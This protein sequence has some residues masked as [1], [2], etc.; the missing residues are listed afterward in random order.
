MKSS[1]E[2]KP[3]TKQTDRIC[4]IHVDHCCSGLQDF[5]PCILSM[6]LWNISPCILACHCETLVHVSYCGN[7]GLLSMCLSM[8]LCDFSPHILAWHCGRNFSPCIQGWHCKS[9]SAAITELGLDDG[10]EAFARTR[11]QFYI[12]KKNA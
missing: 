7:V 2:G 8:A 5:S 1:M 11:N 12:Q 4:I 10:S 3:L 9:G 6:S